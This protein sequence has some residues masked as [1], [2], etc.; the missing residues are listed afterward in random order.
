VV[1]IDIDGTIGDYHGHFLK[2]A[3]DYMGR[4]FDPGYFGGNELHQHMG[5]DLQ[6]YREIKLAYRQGGG[7]RMMPLIPGARSLFSAA[8]AMDAE[9]WVTTT[10]PYNRFDST[11]PD[12]RFWLKKHGLPFDHLLYH[13]DKYIKLAECVD[14]G[15]VVVVVDDLVP[16]LESAAKLFGDRVP[17]QAH[18]VYN[19]RAR[20]EGAGGSLTNA[21][22]YMTKKLREWRKDNA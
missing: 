1:A 7:K 4:D 10:R 2:F 18:S 19:M 13:E 5:L 16:Q 17:F 3:T 21:A 11:D 14:P 12:T 9:V 6:E 22:F 8:M 20:W 15:R